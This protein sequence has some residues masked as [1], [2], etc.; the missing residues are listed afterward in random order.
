MERLYSSGHY[1]LEGIA[2]KVTIVGGGM[3]GLCTAMLL[4]GDDHDVVVLERDGAPPPDPLEAWDTWERKGVNQLR[5]AHFFLSRYKSP[6]RR[7]PQLAVALAAAGA[8]ERRVR[9]ASLTANGGSGPAT[10]RLDCDRID[11]R[12]WVA[13]GDA[14]PTMRGGL[15]RYRR[16]AQRRRDHDVDARGHDPCGHTMHRITNQVVEPCTDGVTA[17]SYVDALV[18]GPGTISG[19]CSAGFYD[20]LVLAEGAWKISRRRFTLVQLQFLPECQHDTLEG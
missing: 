1:N 11:R 5:M 7:V 4:A 20:G 19:A 16:L 18:F 8:C 12:D 2:M 14:S 9:A 13:F 17:R 6:G 10:T 15:W 3:M